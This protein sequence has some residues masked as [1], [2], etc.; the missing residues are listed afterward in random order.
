[1][2]QVITFEHLQESLLAAFKHYGWDITDYDVWVGI[3]TYFSE[4]L[5]DKLNCKEVKELEK[6]E[7]LKKEPDNCLH[8]EKWDKKESEIKKQYKKLF[9]KLYIK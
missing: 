9:W 5:W 6:M 8:K 2:K 4:C 1:M 3:N 7:K